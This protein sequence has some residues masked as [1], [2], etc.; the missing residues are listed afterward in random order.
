MSRIVRS[1]AWL[2]VLVL[3]GFSLVHDASAVQAHPAVAALQV[4]QSAFGS[5][6]WLRPKDIVNVDSLSVAPSLGGMVGVP[7]GGG[8]VT[9]YTVPADRWLVITNWRQNGSGL[10][11]LAEDLSG[12]LTVKRAGTWGITPN[13]GGG[14]TTD[15]ADYAPPL[16][17]AFQ[18]GSNVVLQ[19]TNGG[20]GTTWVRFTFTGYL[21]AD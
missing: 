13:I 2:L 5:G 3:L 18:P 6:T 12:V 8:A 14:G 1:P 21:A 15:S 16:G 7:W 17:I 4:T 19:E 9:I 20:S 11:S 10:T